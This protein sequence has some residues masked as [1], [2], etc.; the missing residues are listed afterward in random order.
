MDK[1]DLVSIIDK[2][3]KPLGFK[4]VGNYWKL[5]GKEII[6]I[7]YLQRSSYSKLYYINYGFNFVNLEYDGVS[8]HV[9]HRLG[10]PDK[11]ENELIQ[12]L[13]DF[14]NDIDSETRTIQLTDIVRNVLKVEL[15]KINCEN[16]VLKEI[17]E[18]P[19]LLNLLPLKV[20]E[21]LEV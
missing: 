8:I 10:S 6:K 5:L 1:K 15:G 16:D 2:E 12:S 11:K 14:E 4:R 21:Y 19:I 3:F 13:L 9:F 7:I 17:E 18:K 20:K